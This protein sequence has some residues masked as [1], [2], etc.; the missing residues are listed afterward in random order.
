MSDHLTP[1]QEAE[2]ATWQYKTVAATQGPKSKL[3][4]ILLAILNRSVRRPAFG[5]SCVITSDGYVLSNFV[6]RHGSM[7]VGAFVCH[8]SELVSN[9]KGLA[10]HCELEQNDRQELFEE[11]RKWVAIDYRPRVPIS[12]H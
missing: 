9:F 11:V 6:D 10:D 4:T 7:H 8:I 2:R 12:L 3:G 1:E 5:P